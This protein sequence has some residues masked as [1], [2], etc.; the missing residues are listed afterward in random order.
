LYDSIEVV[1][2]KTE[3]DTIKVEM[4]PWEVESR[5]IVIRNNSDKTVYYSLAIPLKSQN[6]GYSIYAWLGGVSY[7]EE[8]LPNPIPI[9]SMKNET[10][11]IP[12]FVKNDT[13]RI[14]MSFDQNYSLYPELIFEKPINIE[15]NEKKRN[16]STDQ[17][18]ILWNQETDYE[19]ISFSDD[20][21]ITKYKDK[22]FAYNKKD[23]LLE[24]SWDLPSNKIDIQVSDEN[25]II[26]VNSYSDKS[27]YILSSATGQL[28]YTEE[29]MEFVTLCHDKGK[30]LYIEKDNDQV[31][32]IDMITGTIDWAVANDYDIEDYTI[33]NLDRYTLS[34]YDQSNLNT[35][36]IMNIDDGSVKLQDN[37]N[38]SLDIDCEYCL[39]YENNSSVRK[40]IIDCPKKNIH[41]SDNTLNMLNSLVQTDSHSS[42]YEYNR[43]WYK[44]NDCIIA[45]Y[46]RLVN[47]K[48]LPIEDLFL[49]EAYNAQTGDRICQINAYEKIDELIVK[50]NIISCVFSD[51]Y[52]S[53]SDSH[54]NVSFSIDT[55]QQLD[56]PQ[57]YRLLDYDEEGDT[58][59]FYDHEKGK[60]ICARLD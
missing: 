29:D 26:L 49:I 13:V 18:E 39:S 16:I 4:H 48:D 11:T 47:E 37:S 52:L 24:W 9:D 32:C 57:T 56:I 27:V 54:S 19:F 25:D 6:K 43:Q 41:E 17:L 33:I 1:W 21:V 35:M 3:T 34:F 55:G 50:G 59:F 36:Y 45:M 53:S 51:H 15:V 38:K 12:V 42:D 60:V 5:E 7:R 23:G 30:I 10:I 2:R 14:Q 31:Y 22:A 8:S 28:L 46:T 40:I 58:Y 44:K 20:Q